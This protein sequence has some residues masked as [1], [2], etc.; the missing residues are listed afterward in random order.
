MDRYGIFAWFGY[1]YPIGERVRLIRKA[2]Y[3]ATSIWL[4]RQ[5][6]LVYEGKAD[7]VPGII[8]AGGLFLEYVHASYANCNRLW[9]QSPPERDLISSDYAEAI[10]YCGKHEIP[11]VVMHIVKGMNPPHYGPAGLERIAELVALAEAAG[12]RIAIENTRHPE[13]V[14]YVLGHIDSPSLGFCYDSSHD[15][16]YSSTPG[17][18]LKRWGHRLL[19]THLSDNDGLTDKHWLPSLGTGDWE[20]IARAFP[21]GVFGSF[22]TLEVLPKRDAFGPAPEFLRQGIDL[23]DWFAEMA[24]PRTLA[25]PSPISLRAT[26][27]AIDDLPASVP[28]APAEPSPI[29][30]RAVVDPIP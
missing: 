1:R 19:V 5:E 14:D 28:G 2:G 30:L 7:L 20:S 9:S 8:R 29:S 17:A 15:F 26:R 16:L 24:R 23:L 3:A 27:S 13:Y 10:R 6:P 21:A 11:V 22:L 4:G 18:I 25:E 12:V